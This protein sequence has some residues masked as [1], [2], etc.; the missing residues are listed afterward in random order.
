[1]AVA[2]FI[3][4]SLIN[5]SNISLVMRLGLIILLAMLMIGVAFG[6]VDSYTVG[7]Y[8]FSFDMGFPTDLEPMGPEFSETLDGTAT[9]TYGLNGGDQNGILDLSV[10]EYA[11]GADFSGWYQG[12]THRIVD[13]HEAMINKSEDKKLGS[14]YVACWS[15]DDKTGAVILSTYPWDE[16][17][18][19]L[20]KTIH[21]ENGAA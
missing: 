13:G 2:L 3:A 8:K 14:V 4:P 7:P 21:I 16:G 17:T 18:L 1:L 5:S 10:R 11:Q 15:I 12:T 6:E 20:L 9:T 19:R